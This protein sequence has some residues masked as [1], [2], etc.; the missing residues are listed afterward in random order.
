[1]NEAV[2][3]PF[4]TAGGEMHEEC[5]IS[6]VGKKYLHRHIAPSGFAR[7]NILLR[8]L[9]LPLAIISC[10][11]LAVAEVH[12]MFTVVLTLIFGK[13]NTVKNGVS[14]TSIITAKH[15]AVGNVIGISEDSLACFFTSYLV[16]IY[17]KFLAVYRFVFEGTVFGKYSSTSTSLT[18]I[19][20][21][22]ARTQF[23]DA[24]V[25]NSEPRQLVIL[26]AGMDTRAHR[27]RLPTHCRCFEVDAPATQKFK[28]DI[29]APAQF[30]LFMAQEHMP[31]KHEFQGKTFTN[32]EV[33]YV[34][35]DFEEQGPESDVLMRLQQN[36]FNILKPAT[37]VLE[38][39]SYYVT[40][41]SV[42]DILSMVA[43][44][45]PGSTIAFDFATDFWSDS[46][47]TDPTV[48][49]FMHFLERIGEPFRYG[50]SPD[51]TP[52]ESFSCNGALEVEVWL[53][54]KELQR[55][56]LNITDDRYLMSKYHNFL[57]NFVIMKVK[58]KDK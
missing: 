25:E 54:P 18:S 5:V 9:V 48:K 56:Y 43:K 50:I 51:S 46:A 17:A 41:Q 2:E 58:A 3:A 30:K 4:L 40:E 36:G 47:L 26:G 44:C 33:H 38:G 35:V 23:L 16:T 10:V 6:E 8:I 20:Y 42:K 37:F 15:R 1:M 11:F 52:M 49:Q 32:T 19:G 22:S 21:L 27:L 12:F 39:V 31:D 24:F 53:G 13:K 28:K 55:R 7:I 29:I 34:P 45:A 14:I 57:M